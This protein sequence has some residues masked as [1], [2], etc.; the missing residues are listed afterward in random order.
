MVT[1]SVHPEL[2]ETS[3]L[4]DCFP[5]D[6]ESLRQQVGGHLLFFTRVECGEVMRMVEA[7]LVTLISHT[8]SV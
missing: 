2:R 5:L 6:R 7:L 4:I 3:K 8:S 1:D